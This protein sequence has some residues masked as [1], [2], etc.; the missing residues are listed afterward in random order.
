MSRTMSS[1]LRFAGPATGAGPGEVLQRARL[2]TL[3]T[4]VAICLS[5]AAALAHAVTT[6]DHLRRWLA[7]GVFFALLALAQ[8]GFA[9]HLYRHRASPRVIML[10]VWGNMSVIVLYVVSRTAGL[11]FAP[12][13]TAHGAPNDPGRA[14]IPGAVEQ[15]GSLDLFSLI[16]ELLLILTLVSLLPARQRRRT[17][18]G[19][20]W[21]GLG[22][23]GLAALGALS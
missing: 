3:T 10:G 23:W 8:G 14:V 12:P 20:M 13:I 21:G 19:L 6:P 17:T 15:V 16:V 5:V 2:R 1:E 22:L 7:S 11:P 18:N 4:D 9:A